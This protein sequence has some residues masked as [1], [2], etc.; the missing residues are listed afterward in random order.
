MVYLEA[1]PDVIQFNELLSRCRNSIYYRQEEDCTHGRGK[2]SKNVDNLSVSLHRSRRS[3]G[4]SKSS[5][6]IEGSF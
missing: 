2:L 3:L 6:V 1:S 4:V 5:G